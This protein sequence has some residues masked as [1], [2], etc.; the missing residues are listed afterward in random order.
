M[1]VK[2]DDLKIG[3]KNLS[4]NI[5]LNIKAGEHVAILGKNGQGKTTLIKKIFDEL[6][7]KENIKLG[8]MPQNY[9]DMF[10]E[11]IS[12]LDFLCK[13]KSKEEITKARAYLG[14][15]KFTRDEMI[16]TTLLLSGGQRAK[17]LLVKFVLDGDNVLVLDEPTRNLSP[18]SNGIIR[19]VLKDYTGTIISVS[20]DRKYIK[21][22]CN[23]IYELTSDGLKQIYFE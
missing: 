4:K 15:M 10:D 23:K 2:I 22:C 8:Y 14:A 21:E 20:H 18:L 7:N 5:K 16:S 13:D 9:E 1:D 19:K 6:K 17:L 11:N 12:C 3:E